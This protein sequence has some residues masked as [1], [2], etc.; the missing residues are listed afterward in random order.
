MRYESE[1]LVFLNPPLDNYQAPRKV[2]GADQSDRIPIMRLEE[3]AHLRELPLFSDMSDESF[4]E[5][6]RA[7]YL[8]IF[9]PHVRL[10]NEGDP[11]DFLYV[12]IEGCVEL[13]A[14]ANGRDTT[15]ALSRPL[16][17]FILA[18]VLKDAVYLM[19][20]RT[21]E[22][23]RI[24]LIPAE[25]VRQVMDK[26]MAFTHAIVDDLAHSY[27]TIVKSHKNHRLRTTIERL[28]NYLLSENASQKGKGH[29]TLQHDKR[30]LASLLGMTPENLSRAFNTLRQYEVEIDGRD[31][32]I[33]NEKDLRVLA[34]PTPLIDDD[35]T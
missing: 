1:R 6:L 11:A 8:Q 23:S 20:A 13:F 28:A 4:E 34:K 27:R 16:S 14:E 30:R 3:H 22:K 19:S 10:I 35:T 9:P 12:V 26:D 24:L 33:N 5:L 15:V 25:N 31:V 17:T 21:T 32:R 7:A 2:S 18:A 29:I